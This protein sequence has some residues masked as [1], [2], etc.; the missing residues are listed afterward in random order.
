MTEEN[1]ESTPFAP[2]LSEIQKFK[3]RGRIFT[4]MMFI[5]L[6]ACIVSIFFFL[7][8]LLSSLGFSILAIIA[9][10]F[11]LF[12]AIISYLATL[13]I[14]KALRSMISH[15]EKLARNTIFMIIPP[16]GDNPKER[17]LNQL[18]ET[19]VRIRRALEK[20]PKSVHFDAK[21]NG[22]NGSEYIFDLFLHDNA[23][24][25]W[26]FL[27]LGYAGVDVFVKRFEQKKVTR[28]MTI[29]LKNNVIKTLKKRGKKTP[30]RVLIIATLGFDDLVFS[31]VD[32]EE[33]I[34]E[35]T[36]WES[37]CK[38]ELVKENVDGTFDVL[39]Y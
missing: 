32:S 3:K 27:R 24:R 31:Y 19:D 34:F 14:P 35:R 5:S 16:H 1:I 8:F 22:N 37:E 33:G 21:A 11:L 6:P 9:F 10:G 18:K 26:K 23:S 20:N 7:I 29:E 15:M 28:E 13:L 4:I 25:T 12:S 2:L 17:I 30:M 39:S 38:I 36:F